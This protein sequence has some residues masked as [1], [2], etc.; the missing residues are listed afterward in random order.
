[1]RVDH[2]RDTWPMCDLRLMNII[3]IDMKN[4]AKPYHYI[5]NCKCDDE[6]SRGINHINMFFLD[7]NTTV[8]RKYRTL[9]KTKQNT[10][11]SVEKSS[12]A[13][14]NSRT[15]SHQSVIT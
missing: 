8:E 3:A 10:K 12:M 4:G 2:E 6:C 7:N 14:N 11:E 13:P 1:M 15:K 9:Y 5:S